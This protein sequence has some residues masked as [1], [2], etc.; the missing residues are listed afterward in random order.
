MVTISNCDSKKKMSQRIQR[1][2]VLIVYPIYLEV[3]KD[4]KGYVEHERNE[5]I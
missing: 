3:L 5:K 4:E 2:N 1:E